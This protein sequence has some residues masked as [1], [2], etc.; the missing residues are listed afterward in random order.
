[1]ESKTLALR[2]DHRFCDTCWKGWVDAEFEKKVCP[3]FMM[4]V[5]CSICCLRRSLL[6][7]LALAAAP[8][9]HC[10]VSLHLL[11]LYCVGWV[12]GVCGLHLRELSPF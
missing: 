8:L 3:C 11:R 1:M 10:S 7:L 9:L 2:C 4:L 6:C 12:V 5:L